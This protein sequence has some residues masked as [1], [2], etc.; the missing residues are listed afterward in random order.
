MQ[1]TMTGFTDIAALP[2]MQSLWAES[3]GDIRVCIAILDGPV[4]QTHPCLKGANLTRLPTL[5]ADSAGAGPMAGHGTHITSVVF[6][7]PGN[8]VQGIAPGCRGLIVPVFSDSRQGPLSQLDLARAINQAVEQGAHVINIS[9]GQL[10]QPG[11]ADPMLVNAVRS[12]QD[13][14]VLIVAAAGNDA[15]Q[16]LHVPAALPSVLAV[17]A[18]NAQGI[19]FDFSNWGE[20]YQTQGILAPGEKIF[21]GM[22][23]GG[24]A[25]KSGTSFATPIVSGIVALL[26]S[27]QLKRGE[28]LNPDVIRNAILKSAS[29]CNSTMAL[30]CRRFLAGRLNIPGAYALVTEGG[31]E[32]MAGQKPEEKKLIQPSEMNS[33][34]PLEPD[35]SKIAEQI[36]Q[37]VIANVP[38]LN[39]QMA[40][41]SSERNPSPVPLV[42]SMSGTPNP[43]AISHTVVGIPVMPGGNG[44]YFVPDPNGVGG[45]YVMPY[46]SSMAVT[47]SQFATPAMPSSHMPPNP[48]PSN[49]PGTSAVTPSNVVA[50]EGC[51]CNGGQ[52][53]LVYALG[54]LGYD[55]G[56]EARRDSFKQLM[57]WTNIPVIEAD[58]P[59]PSTGTTT[60]LNVTGMRLPPN[61]YDARQMAEYLKKHPSEAKSLIWTLN[62]ELTPIY[63]IEP[64]GPFAGEVYKTLVEFLDGQTRHEQDLNYIE[65]VSI[66]GVLT[67]RTITLFSGQVVPVIEPVN[68]RGMYSWRVRVLIHDLLTQ[69]VEELGQLPA[70]DSILNT[71]QKNTI[72]QSNDLAPDSGSSTTNWA[73]FWN[74]LSD[75]EKLRLLVPYR[76]ESLPDER[77][78]YVRMLESSIEGFLLRIYYDLRNLGQTSSERA[79]N[80][81]ATNS[82]QFGSAV[83]KALE[84]RPSDTNTRGVMQLDGFTIEKSPFCR[85]DSDCWDVKIKFF[86]PEND[87]RARKVVRYTIDVSDVMPVTLGEPRMWE[88]PN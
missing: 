55:F 10:S 32:Q 72:L 79:L 65:R 80:F 54:L 9:G 5:I 21:G 86:D 45:M 77:K 57:S 75:D 63:A 87:R 41:Q 83:A 16:C 11:E 73:R 47:P 38:G 68:T 22:P 33:I 36:G 66:P 71:I 29:P 37:P 70:S 84:A 14:G 76:R 85:V 46:T 7:Q 39:G 24:F 50:S 69:L 25:T 81:A 74:S 67:G 31:A 59:T 34:N 18:M 27:I 13:N 51:G 8:P 53:S 40:D 82:F 88:V 60:Q 62:L 12:C 15:C 56:T 3:L 2:G 44:M 4:D 17:G 49:Y 52:K 61:P 30:D 6:S 48:M 20:A 35:H 23:D 19:P 64:Q 1:S 43:G 28:P 78:A 58:Q 42:N 26:L